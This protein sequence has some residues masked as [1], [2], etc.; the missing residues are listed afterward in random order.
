MKAILKR[1]FYQIRKSFLLA[2]GII[3]LSQLQVIIG[4]IRGHVELDA[5]IFFTM[6]NGMMFASTGYGSYSNDLNTK[7]LEYMRSMPISLEDYGTEKILLSVIPSTFIISIIMLVF[8]LRI[9]TDMNVFLLWAILLL[10]S[11]IIGISALVLLVKFGKNSKIARNLLMVVFM[12]ALLSFFAGYFTV[13]KISL[14][15]N[16]YVLGILM[17]AFILILILYKKMWKK[18]MEALR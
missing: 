8:S 15:L 14:F 4:L 1:D 10:L 2:F 3:V 9:K 6:I 5:L 17:I 12:I 7:F 18:E 11:L 16:Y 13:Q